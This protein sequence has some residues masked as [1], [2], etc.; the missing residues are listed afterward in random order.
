MWYGLLNGAKFPGQCCSCWSSLSRF[1]WRYVRTD[2]RQLC[3]LE[4]AT[5]RSAAS[6]MLVSVA[7]PHGGVDCGAVWGPSTQVQ[8]R[9]GHVH[10]DMAPQN[11]MHL[12]T[13]LDKHLCA[14]VVSE[15]PPPPHSL[16]LQACPFFVFLVN[17]MMASGQLSAAQ[18][19]RCV[20]C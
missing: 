3:V 5:V 14:Q 9:G 12:C 16:F 17:E 1:T 11:K 18:R 20:P 4:R 13:W 2:T 19:R 8:C 7:S 10:R 15:P 6:R